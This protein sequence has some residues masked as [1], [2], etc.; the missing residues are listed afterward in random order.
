MHYRYEPTNLASHDSKCPV[1]AFYIPSIL[2]LELGVLYDKYPSNLNN[3]GIE[4]RI[5]NRLVL[6]AILTNP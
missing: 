1:L 4:A 3:S 6:P 5:V 2:R